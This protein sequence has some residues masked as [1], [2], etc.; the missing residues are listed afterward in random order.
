MLYINL[1][2]FT[3]VNCQ[4]Q[5][6]SLLKT[7][8]VT[9][10]TIEV[11]PFGNFFL[12][13]DYKISK[14]SENGLLLNVYHQIENG[15]I[16]NVDVSNPLKPIV[17][18]KDFNIV[19]VLD[20]KLSLINEINLTERNL[21]FVQAF[22]IAN[23]DN[24]WV[25]DNLTMTLKKLDKSFNKGYE[26]ISF[27]NLF[28]KSLEPIKIKERAQSVFVLDD[29]GIHLFDNFANFQKTIRIQGLIDFQIIKGKLIYLD[30]KKLISYNLKTMQVEVLSLPE[31]KYLENAKIYKNGLLLLAEKQLYIYSIK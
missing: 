3:I 31:I 19:V 28:T 16:T 2:L 7:I 5:E 10:N 8:K 30:Q 4:A 1:F 13:E 21:D 6:Y 20:Q 23:G 24:Y 26:S 27:L 25:Y 9:A 22:A 14:Y 18:F 12:V 15:T 11:D 17:F 29:S